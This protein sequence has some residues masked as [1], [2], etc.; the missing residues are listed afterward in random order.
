[1]EKYKLG[2]MDET[3]IP[4][5]HNKPNSDIWHKLGFSFISIHK[6]NTNDLLCVAYCGTI[7]LKTQVNLVT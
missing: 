5:I 4:A 7:S 2:L 1:V 6:T 3:K